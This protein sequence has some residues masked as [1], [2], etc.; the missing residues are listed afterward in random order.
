[1]SAVRSRADEIADLVRRPIWVGD[2]MLS[3]SAS[4][5]IALSG[6]VPKSGDELLR[7]ADAALYGAKALPRRPS[8]LLDPTA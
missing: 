6:D 8:V 2:R 1:M 5:G 7:E 4:V 3:L